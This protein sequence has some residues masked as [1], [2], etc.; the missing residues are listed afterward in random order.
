MPAPTADCE[1]SEL[2]KPD[3]YQQRITMLTGQHLCPRKVYQAHE[4][5]IIYQ[6]QERMRRYAAQPKL[7]ARQRVLFITTS[8]IAILLAILLWEKHLHL[9]AAP[10]N[11]TR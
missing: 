5:A 6:T 8:F 9:R 2:V 1:T 4:F 10:A 7:L 3:S 11:A